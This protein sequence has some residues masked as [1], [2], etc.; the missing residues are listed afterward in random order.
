MRYGDTRVEKVKDLKKGYTLYRC[1]NAGGVQYSY[2][3]DKDGNEYFSCETIKEN[4]MLYWF[5][6]SI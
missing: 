6:Q 2:I 5:E 3:E 4:E 1:V